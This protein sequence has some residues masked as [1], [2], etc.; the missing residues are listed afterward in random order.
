MCLLLTAKTRKILL[1]NDLDQ[2]QCKTF[3]FFLN[4]IDHESKLEL[5]Q[6]F[7]NL[8]ISDELFFIYYS[9]ITHQIY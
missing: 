9:L 7:P 3:L 5:F 2:D 4:I 8:T 1:I 6:R